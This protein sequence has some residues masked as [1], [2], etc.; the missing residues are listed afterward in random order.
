MRCAPSDTPGVLTY[1]SHRTVEATAVQ[2]SSVEE[3]ALRSLIGWPESCCNPALVLRL[4]GDG[5]E[6]ARTRRAHCIP[7]FAPHRGLCWLQCFLL[8]ASHHVGIVPCYFRVAV[9][10]LRVATYAR[11][12]VSTCWSKLVMSD[13]A[14]YP[15]ACYGRRAPSDFD[16]GGHLRR[17]IA[18]PK[19]GFGGK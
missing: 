11:I 1:P 18:H 14:P 9:G 4:L 10:L 8:R 12:S 16:D 2:N 19:P 13:R 6:A 17:P 3:C 15:D 5:R 7:S